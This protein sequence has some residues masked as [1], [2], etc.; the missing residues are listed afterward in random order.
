MQRNVKR[1]A[2]IKDIAKIA[3][4]AQGTVSNVLNGR[5]NVSSDKIRRV[6]DACEQLGYIPNE[7]A[8]QLRQTRSR[9]IG[10]LLPNLRD[11]RPIDFYISFKTYAE[12]HGY[13]VRQYLSSELDGQQ[14]EEAV[15]QEVLKDGID[16]MAVFAGS[17]HM[18]SVP[19]GKRIPVIYVEHRPS[20][21]ADFIGFDYRQAGSS[22]AQQVRKD[23][24]SNVVLLTGSL[25]ASSTA[26]FCAGFQAAMAGASAR[27]THIQT[28]KQSEQLSILESRELSCADAVVCSRMELAQVARN[29]LKSFSS[30]ALPRIYT[31]SPL[32]TLPESDFNKYELNYRLLGDATAKK[33]IQQIEAQTPAGD[34]ILE[35][36]GFRSF[37][38]PPVAHA[39]GQALSVITLDSPEAYTLQHIAK[40]YTNQ[41]GVPVH[42]GIYSYDEIFDIFASGMRGH[43]HYDVLR[44]DVTMLSFFARK[45]LMPLTD[46]DPSIADFLSTFLKGTVAPYSY[47]NNTLYSVPFSPSTQM[48]YYRR[49]LFS[50]SMIR[51]MFVE[52]FGRELTVPKTFDEYNEIASF[53]TRSLNPDSPVKFGTT[54]TVGSIAVASSE[55]LQ[56]LFALQEN[57]YDETGKVDMRAPNFVRA[58]EQLLA[59]RPYADPNYSTW[60][61]NTVSA[62]AGGDIAMALIYNNFASPLVSYQSRVR[63]SIGY[64][65][66]PGGRPVIGGGCLG[67]SR[68]SRH[69]ELAL[70]FI[71]W[72]CSE[73]IS[74]A[75][76]FL[77]GVSP[78]TESYNNYEIINTY[79]WLKNV[80]R[81]FAAARGRR[82]PPHV[83]TP[84]DE[85]AFL[86][87]IGNSVLQA[88]SGALSPEQAMA[89]AHRRFQER[90]GAIYTNG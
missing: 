6:L 17:Q 5:G 38:P 83:E 71:R 47:V 19:F 21:V 34:Q 13:R 74:S 58:L 35:N 22:I 27:I 50:N 20:F 33:L 15:Q 57:L 86:N 72:L 87:I 76:A 12:N 66:I 68:L 11:K 48:L 18:M 61:R 37:T 24:C 41:T 90:F 80:N 28:D 23:R 42:I 67:I 54:L 39:D 56:R 73:P 31:L 55:Y 4:V 81:S 79:P 9:L 26:E 46:I 62:F 44:I 40:L 32:F 45:L 7:Q 75:S 53:F 43:E 16:A 14:S 29:L 30:P 52:R 3:G 84:F 63:D 10:V 8:K 88:C 70:S 78:C 25:W 59:A 77:G 65:L 82:V 69:P 49:D 36:N 51:R 60:W 85:R 2:T 1:M 89:L 64:A